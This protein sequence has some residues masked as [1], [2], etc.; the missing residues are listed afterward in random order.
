MSTTLSA[1]LLK[2]LYF[3]SNSNLNFMP[4][5]CNDVFFFIWILFSHRLGLTVFVLIKSNKEQ[6][7]YVQSNLCARVCLFEQYYLDLFFHLLCKFASTFVVLVLVWHESQIW[8]GRWRWS[9][10]ECL[11]NCLDILFKWCIQLWM[12]F[13]FLKKKVYS[14]EW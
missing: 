11:M 13:S 9:F 12:S 1:K 5:Q 7:C 3:H 4:A 8:I 2:F 14:S 10:Y 6:C